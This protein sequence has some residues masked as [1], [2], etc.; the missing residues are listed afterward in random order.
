M[1]ID[2]TAG[3][4]RFEQN[5]EDRNRWDDIWGLAGND[6]IRLYQGMVRSGPGSDRIERIFDPSNP[7]RSVQY[8]GDGRGP[9]K[10]DLQEG[11]AV[12]DYG[13]RDILIGVNGVHGSNHNDWFKGDAGNNFF[14][15][16]GGLD[17]VLGGNGDDGVHVPSFEPSPGARW[18]APDVSELKISVSADGRSARVLPLTGRGF[19]IELQDVEYL[20]VRANGVW[21][22][23][24]LADYVTQ[25]SMAQQ[26]LLGLD[27]NRWNASGALGTGANL[28]FSF[29]GTAPTSGPGA[30][31]FRAFSDSER[32]YVR[33]ILAQVSDFT[34]LRFTEV[35]ET[36]SNTG[37]LRFGVS[38]QA[39]TKG[40]SWLPG[41]AGALS[42]DVW[43][44]VESMVGL[45]PGTEGYQALL[46][47]IG[48]ALG[49]RHPRNQDPSD[50]W[51]QQLR[52]VDDKTGHTVMS[53]Q[54]SADALFRST[55]GPLDILAL[56]HLYG[57][58]NLYAANSTH[59]LE[60][61]D[62]LHQFTILDDG[63]VDT[64]DASKLKTAVNISLRPGSFSSVGV[65]G[66][67]RA[68]VD[69]LAIPET[70]VIEN[71]V[72][73]DLDDV[74]IGNAADNRIEG[75]RGNDWID[76]SA[77]V[78]T[79]VFSES[80]SA[81]RIYNAYGVVYV[82]ALDGVSGYDSLVNVERLAFADKTVDAD[83]LRIVGD[84]RQSETLTAVVT[85]SQ[86]ERVAGELRYQWRVNDNAI[87]GATGRTYSPTQSDV[88]Q[89]ISVVVTYT[90][91]LGQPGSFLARPSQAV[92][93]AND[94]PTGTVRIEGTPS[95]GQT[96]RVV[97]KLEDLDG[98]GGNW[99]V[100]RRNGVDI[101]DTNSDTYVVRKDD[102]GCDITVAVMYWD[103]GGTLDGMVSPMPVRISRSP[104]AIG[105]TTPPTVSVTANKAALKAGETAVVTFT[106][107]EA[108]AD[109]TLGD[110][111]TVGGTLSSLSGSG[112]LYQAIFTPTPGRIGPGSLSVPSGVFS[113]LNGNFN[114]DGADANNLV[115]F[116]LSTVIPT[117]VSLSP[118]PMGRKVALDSNLS[119]RFSEPVKPG[120]GRVTLSTLSGQ[121]VE[122]FDAQGGRASWQS[123]TLT[124]DPTMSLQWFTAYQIGFS[125]DVAVNTGGNSPSVG[126]Q[127]TFRT[128]APDAAYSFF[129]VAF[130]AAPGVTYMEQIT[131]ALNGGASMLQVVEAFTTKSQF[132]NIYP[133]SLNNRAF[134]SELVARVVGDS[135]SA[136]VKA[137]AVRDIEYVLDEGVSRGRMIFQVF[138]NLASKPTNDPDWGRTAQ[139]FQN[140]VKVSQYFTEVMGHDTTDLR[141]L[142]SLMSAVTAQTDVSTDALI[143]Q[144]IGA[145]TGLQS[146]SGL[147]TGWTG[148]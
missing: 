127:G 107:S 22:R 101:N 15:V 65:T 123:D 20:W 14:W 68:A 43:M 131:T 23:V 83:N 60:S 113:D 70:T 145:V 48:H 67:G 119:F 137:Q 87:P 51:A 134:A 126:V 148:P 90:D 50:N 133:T 97:W 18:R 40:V 76:G 130:G 102:L 38:Q 89:T 125:G 17:T 111:T 74:L 95:V 45:K 13:D 104:S 34:G 81:Y 108:C 92:E 110:V 31:G 46:H 63:G 26:G 144:L 117:L 21:G 120:T 136:L 54:V 8:A 58:S 94:R 85:M 77:G 132:T 139:Q 105:D 9:I 29:V 32:A 3:D 72:G 47:E 1:R 143:V 7:N 56:R 69:N 36:G 79:V 53:Q 64:L 42:G 124:I 12:D 86:P 118:V 62:G 140:Q 142:Q 5:Y 147:G 49:L 4:D 73:T 135:A 52:A 28:T 41:S 116:G 78:D 19:E 115:Q 33:L 103:W 11:W 114:T 146:P 2:L 37:A 122:V 99:F 61:S 112:Q 30:S 24:N 57:T 128:A 129:A 75:R 141:T 93:N 80:M 100:W 25:A 82:E 96:L 84:I 91:T 59:L 138:G 121:T 66:D 71:A 35:T 44:D 6:V 16:N 98:F 88:N 27:Q 106:F 55:W 109:F 39:N 10:V